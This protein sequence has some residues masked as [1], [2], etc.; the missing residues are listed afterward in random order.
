MVNDNAVVIVDGYNYLYSI[1]KNRINKMELEQ[2]RNRLIEDL[3]QLAKYEDC[4]VIVVFDALK[5][6]G[7]LHKNTKV[8]LV[9]IL[10]TKK[11]QSA[12]DLAEKLVYKNK[13]KKIFVVTSDYTQQ[14]ITFGSGAFRMTTKQLKNE[15]DQLKREIR[16][17]AAFSSKLNIPISKRIDKKITKE[18]GKLRKG[19][20]EV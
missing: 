19:K 20:V 3:N 10:F 12:D 7:I 18:L 1:E 5:G 4:Q 2:L 11:G 9:E 15:L 8:N 13:G 16:S 14:R 17:R 6:N